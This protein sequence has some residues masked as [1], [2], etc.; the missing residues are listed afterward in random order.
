MLSE[1]IETMLT[2]HKDCVSG[3]NMNK[4]EN[5][6]ENES[7]AKTAT[8]PTEIIEMKSSFDS[9]MSGAPYDYV[10]LTDCVFAPELAVPLVN[11]ILCGCGPRTNVL[12]C[13]EIRD[14]VSCSVSSFILT[15]LRCYATSPDTHIF[16]CVVLLLVNILVLNFDSSGS[17]CRVH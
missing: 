2:N 1:N 6:I 13:H 4:S 9:L 12:C 16:R 15:I 7:A 17:K 5:E 10:L 14:E 8:T 3:E 11:T